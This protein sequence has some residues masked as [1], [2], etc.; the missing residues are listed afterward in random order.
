[1]RQKEMEEYSYNPNSDPTIPVA[2]A[3]SSNGDDQNGEGG[4]YRGWGT[5][6]SAGPR[7]PSTTLGGSSNPGAI[8][9]ARSDS[10][11][12]GY[13]DHSPHAITPEKNG[14]VTGSPDGI[15]LLGTGPLASNNKNQ[16]VNRGISNASSAY[17][18]GQK[19]NGSDNAAGGFA[20]SPQQYYD[21]LMQPDEGGHEG[22]GQPVI[23]DVSARRNTRIENPAI[24]P[25]HGNAGIAQNF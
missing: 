3:V 21:E 23:R 7:K 12:R 22:Y 6:S 17:S 14:S 13:D 24:Y 19:S 8:G 20:G 15:G 2:G 10:G 5:T 1:M 25:Q 11:G 9:I 18:G 16:G 4:G